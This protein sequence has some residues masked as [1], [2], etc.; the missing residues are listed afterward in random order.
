MNVG[1]KKLCLTTIMIYRDTIKV[2][3]RHAMKYVE[4]RKTGNVMLIRGGGG[5][6]WQRMR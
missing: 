2:C 6:V 1:F 3:Q 4:K 5:T